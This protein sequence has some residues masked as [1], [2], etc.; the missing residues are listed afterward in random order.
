MTLT[1]HRAGGLLQADQ[2]RLPHLADD[3]FVSSEN[4]GIARGDGLALSLTR[5]VMELHGG[6][7]NIVQNADAP[8]A[9]AL[10][11]PVERTIR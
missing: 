9:I 3:P 1:E 2:T 7:L 6:T 10:H 5:K 4:S 11:F 8:A